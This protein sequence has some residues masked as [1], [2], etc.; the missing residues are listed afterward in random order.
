[1]SE[2]T[3]GVGIVGA[4]KRGIGLARCIAQ[5]CAETDFEVTMLCDRNAERMDDA[6]NLLTERFAERG[7]R[8]DIALTDNYRE[9]IDS[10]R[11]DVVMV[12]T[13]Q[14]AHREPTIAALESGKRVYIDK[15]IAHNAADGVAIVEAEARTK[16]PI[17]MGF[18][19]RYEAPWRKA[20]EL[21]REGAIGD[22]HM[23]LLRAVI[24][25]DV[26]FHTW[27]RRRE[28]SGG[29]L[30]DKSSHHFD[31][32]NWFARGR[33]EA[34]SAFGGRGV[35]RPDPEAPVRCLE[36]D[37]DCPYRLGAKPGEAKSA[38]DKMV[39]F[40]QSWDHET[41]ELY[42]HD[43][44]VYRPGS[45]NNDKVTAQFRY[46]NGVIAN[47]FWC[48]FGP[49]A[50]DQET[51]EMVGSRGR[52]ILERHTGTLDIVGDLEARRETMQC[53]DA[54][55]ES[56]HFGADLKLI[57]EMRDFVGGADPVVSARSGLEA[58]RMVMAAHRSIDSGGQLVEMR[59]LPDATV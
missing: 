46:D 45:D 50:D 28:W 22:L 15:P 13:P 30:N 59:D 43:T 18:T 58:T 20:F 19:R 57:R 52:I 48:I 12:V 49:H 3:I 4:G 29:A 2:N 42:R 34:V 21:V 27:H 39:R 7:R 26:Y 51:F 54:D 24:P 38:Q 25:Y 32:F 33:A 37:R 41:E 35:Y 55:F 10:P 36:C 56:S 47:L 44:C 11:V 6:R 17:L 5:T 31:V 9:L 14:Y 8:V 1:M 16:N 53:H 40:G 23:L